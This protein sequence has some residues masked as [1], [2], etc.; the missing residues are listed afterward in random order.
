LREDGVGGGG[1]STVGDGTL[2]AVFVRDAVAV[3][4]SVT[5]ALG[6]RRKREQRVSQ[7]GNDQ[8]PRAPTVGG[9]GCPLD[10]GRRRLGSMRRRGGGKSV[11]VRTGGGS[12]WRQEGAGRWNVQKE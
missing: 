2:A 10:H 7:D 4:G 12:P 5:S 8:R 11:H 6:V 9:R 3:P 1:R